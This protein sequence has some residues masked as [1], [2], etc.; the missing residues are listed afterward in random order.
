MCA[1]RQVLDGLSGL[2]LGPIPD[3]ITNAIFSIVVPA[4]EEGIG[5]AVDQLAAQACEGAL[6]PPPER[7]PLPP[8]SPWTPLPTAAANASGDDALG[9]V[10]RGLPPVECVPE[11]TNRPRLD[12]FLKDVEIV[13]DE[14]QRP[15][16]Y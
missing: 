13:I 6:H 12:G 1:A 15:R 8:P 10:L 2:V 14:P 11:E 5:T 9:L 4:I 3:Q 16:A 7:G